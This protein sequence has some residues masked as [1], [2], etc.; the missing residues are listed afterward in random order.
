LNCFGLDCFKRM[1]KKRYWILFFTLACMLMS[2]LVTQFVL[3][4][5]YALTI[6]LYIQSVDMKSAIRPS[7][8]NL[9]ENEVFSNVIYDKMLGVIIES[10][11]YPVLN[12]SSFYEL[13]YGSDFEAAFYDEFPFRQV[14][15]RLDEIA[16]SEDINLVIEADDPVSA[17]EALE[18]F[19]PQIIER[20]E[21]DFREKLDGI[22][23][24]A[25]SNMESESSKLD[26]LTALLDR[27]SLVT[28]NENQALVLDMKESNQVLSDFE[29][30]KETYESYKLILKE[31]SVK[32]QSVSFQDKIRFYHDKKV[33]EKLTP[34]LEKNLILSFFLGFIVSIMMVCYPVVQS[35]IHRIENDQ[36]L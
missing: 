4:H 22:E 9:E 36:L 2:F 5:R 32:N 30:T 27:Q 25:I 31:L 10:L 18:F 3:E 26:E 24:I 1:L 23:E 8:E 6:R 16:K 20:I 17:H 34:S 14:S 12:R 29:L 35:Y 15:Y 11:D 13:V 33:L 7:A 19:K 21:N 28:S